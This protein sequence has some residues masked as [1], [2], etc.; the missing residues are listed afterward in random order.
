MIFDQDLVGAMTSLKKEREPDEIARALDLLAGRAPGSH[1]VGG[2]IRDALLEGRGVLQYAPTS[3]S[4]PRATDLDVAVA[5]RP[6]IVG[7]AV[8][9]ELG[10][11]LVVLDEERETYRIVLPSGRHID[12]GPLGESLEENLRQRDFT[13]NALAVPLSALATEMQGSG[14]EE[15]WAGNITDLFGGMRDLGD[16]IVRHVSEESFRQDPARLMRAFRLCAQLR[17][18]VPPG[19]TTSGKPGRGQAGRAFH[20]APETEEL[21]R[22]QADL[23]ESVSAERLRDELFLMLSCDCS[24]QMELAWKL[25]LLPRVFPELAPLENLEQGAYHHLDVLAHSLET[26]RQLEELINSLPSWA[27]PPLAGTGLAS[28]VRARLDENL[29]GRPRATARTPPTPC[30]ASASATAR[31]RTRGALLK[32]AGLLHDVGKPLTRSEIRNSKSEI[33]EVHFYDHEVVGADMA[34]AVALRLRLSRREVAKLKNV[35]RHHLRPAFLAGVNSE[36]SAQ[37]GRA[38]RRFL[39]AAGA[40]AVEVLLLS[41]ADKRASRGP[42]GSAEEVATRTQVTIELLHTLCSGGQV[43]FPPRLV[44]GREI[45]ER[46][47]LESGPDVGKLISLVRG[48]QLEEGISTKEQAWELLDRELGRARRDDKTPAD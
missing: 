4:G 27:C 21:I 46:Y 25:G 17:L 12:I 40:D 42:F 7:M 47:G 45:M 48:A 9:L 29:G 15:A 6:G 28:W 35:V 19:E 14:D 26:V 32:L 31:G 30:L 1:L 33:I 22:Q 23:I 20:L 13:M 44:T 24:E 39:T 43:P 10:G 3:G 18:P 38:V 36:R 41:L 16:G 8:A 11:R 37:Q 5:G 34:E 2:W